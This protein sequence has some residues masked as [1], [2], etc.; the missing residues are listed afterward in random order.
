MASLLSDKSQQQNSRQILVVHLMNV[1]C[2]VSLKKKQLL[3]FNFTRP[4]EDEP[5]LF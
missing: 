2:H 1:V 3:I 4:V 5:S